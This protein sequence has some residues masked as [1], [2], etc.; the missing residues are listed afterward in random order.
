MGVK[1]NAYKIHVSKK[2][3]RGHLENLGLDERKVMGLSETEWD[4]IECI[5]G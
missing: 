5:H 2:K 1:R 3:E 4:R